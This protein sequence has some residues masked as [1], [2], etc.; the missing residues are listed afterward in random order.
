MSEFKRRM[1]IKTYFIL[2]IVIFALLVTGCK[3]VSRDIDWDEG[4][5]MTIVE[6]TLYYRI[7]VDK[8]T[9]VM[10]ISS[11]GQHGSPVTMVNA[12]GTPRIWKGKIE[13]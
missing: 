13:E 11:Y 12:D 6:T 7:F 2:V 8:E 9:R 4:S 10:Y 3:D 5:T 1:N